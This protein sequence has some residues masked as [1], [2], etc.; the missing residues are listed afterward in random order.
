MAIWNKGSSIGITADSLATCEYNK[1]QIWII[2][3]RSGQRLFYALRRW[4][5]GQT[6]L[7][8]PRLV[9][10]QAVS[11]DVQIFVSRKD[12][13]IQLS[14]GK[15]FWWIKPTNLAWIDQADPVNPEQGPP[16]PEGPRGPEGRRGPKGETGDQGPAGPPGPQGPPGPPGEPNPN[17]GPEP[18][19][20]VS[21]RWVCLDGQPTPLIGCSLRE[22]LHL[23]SGQIT[24]PEAQGLWRDMGGLRAYEDKLIAGGLNYARFNADADYSLTWGHVKRL[25]SAGIICE[26]TLLQER[27]DLNLGDPFIHIENLKDTLTIFEVSN[28]F[29]TREDYDA[30]LALAQEIRRRYPTALISGG[31]ITGGL[32]FN[33]E[34]YHHVDIAQ[35][36]REWPIEAD[37]H[38]DWV[39]KKFKD[40]PGPVGRNEYFDARM[41]LPSELGLSGVLDIL[42]WSWENGAR[43]INYYPF[44]DSFT[45]PTGGREWFHVYAR[46]FKAFLEEVN[47]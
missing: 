23:E 24:N 4:R 7:T 30:S 5:N 12:G 25:N 15:D 6:E 32:Y 3:F 31:G 18:R 43:L 41:S 40:R 14:C 37:P 34:F 47:P 1:G 44:L 35:V 11:G 20:T 13:F 10:E 46:E 19:L 42:R 26:V 38:A 36:H 28:E 9:T 22:A 27:S 21:G 33:P 29:L 17:P 39:W 16:G 45:G 8:D 2:G